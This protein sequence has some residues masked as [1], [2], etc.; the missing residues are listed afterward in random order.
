MAP[1]DPVVARQEVFQ[2]AFPEVGAVAIGVDADREH[3]ERPVHVRVRCLRREPE[4]REDDASRNGDGAARAAGSGEA[5][6]DGNLGGL[7][8]R[9]HFRLHVMLIADSVISVSHRLDGELAIGRG[10]RNQFA[11]GKFFWS[12]AL[13]D[14]YMSAFC[15]NY[16]VVRTGQGRET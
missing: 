16:R 14:I 1:A 5:R 11:A 4:R 12:A 15:A 8:D 13:I 3:P 9:N 7:R 6:R 2:A 10:N